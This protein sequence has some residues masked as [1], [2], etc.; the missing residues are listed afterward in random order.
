M[1]L[2][3]RGHIRKQVVKLSHYTDLVQY[4]LVILAI[5]AYGLA[6]IPLS[7]PPLSDVII[8]LRFRA[9]C[10]DFRA[11]FSNPCSPQQL[12]PLLTLAYCSAQ[13]AEEA[14][15]SFERYL[16]WYS[17][18]PDWDRLQLYIRPCYSQVHTRT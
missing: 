14:V 13:L 7:Y 16:S 17:M 10:A 15:C 3:C 4:V 18:G 2:D 5:T 8:T 1:F 6:D 11:T 9:L 12:L